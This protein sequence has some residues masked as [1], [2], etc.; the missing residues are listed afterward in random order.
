MMNWGAHDLTNIAEKYGTPYYL[1][2][3][4]AAR[5]HLAAL[6]EH[7]PG[8]VEVLYCVKAN[9]NPR[10]ITAFQELVPGLD[11]SSGGE[12]ELACAAGWSPS[13]MSFAG[14][15]KT[16]SE[17]RLSISRGLGSISIES[18]TELNRISA[19]ALEQKRTVR[20]LLRINPA[21]APK[22]FAMKMGG[23]ASQFGVQ[24]EDSAAVFKQALNAPGIKL[25]GIHI[26]SGTQCLELP[27]LVENVEQTLGIAASLAT[28]NN[29][30]LEE[31]NLGGGIGVAYFPG[32][33]DLS[34]TQVSRALADSILAFRTRHP[35]FVQTK[36]VVELGRYL[37]AR[38]GVYVTRVVDAKL[39]RDRRFVIMD[40]GMNHCFPATG[41]FGQLVKKNYPVENLSRSVA[42][43]EWVPQE[44]VGPLC[45]PLDSM[46][47]NVALPLCETGDLIAVKNCGAYSFSASPLMFL[48]HATPLELLSFKGELSVARRRILASEFV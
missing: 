20:C 35:R 5:V 13:K 26:F 10:I 22:G 34:P 18:V 11:I 19:L 15:G 28:A 47:R 16:E 48:S 33:E 41:N 2:D 27:A 29:V 42:E 4:D 38:F 23:L 30:T 6:R 43:N 24:E 7:L 40:G 12:V 39:T 1:Y 37:I 36:I 32:Q 25:A 21:S 8:N 45:T 14:P 17:L 31:I 44:L 46:A 3:L 9:P